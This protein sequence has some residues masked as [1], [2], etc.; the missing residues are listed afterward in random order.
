MTAK[1]LGTQLRQVRGLRGW[2]LRE[3]AEKAEISPAYLQKLEQGN[4]HAP[5]PHVLY[6][7]A[8]HLGAPYSNLM[9][10]AGYVVP[11]P[12]AERLALPSISPLAYAL[13]SED[14]SEEEAEALAQ[15]LA[16]YR[17]QQTSK[18]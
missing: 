15:Y 6:R 14:L 16:W 3:T 10:L 9:E 2:S 18:T 12:G 17:S 4:V 11:D 5:S 13:S 8:E 7:L 1:E